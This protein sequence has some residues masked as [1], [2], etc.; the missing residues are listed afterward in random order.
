MLAH[1]DRVLSFIPYHLEKA[2]EKKAALATKKTR[3]RRTS[4]S[5]QETCKMQAIQ[6]SFLWNGNQ[7]QRE[8]QRE[9]Q[10]E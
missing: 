6:L 2:R 8:D 3:T 9:D 1:I 5:D 7:D 4:K 10:D